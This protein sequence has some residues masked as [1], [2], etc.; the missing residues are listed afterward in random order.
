[1]NTTKR[2][3]VIAKYRKE[4]ANVMRSRYHDVLE[5]DGKIEYKIYIWEDGNIECLE[6]PRG[7]TSRLVPNNGE[8]RKLFYVDTVMVDPSFDPW[9]CTDHSAP[10]DEDER[11]S[12]R[13]EIYDWLEEQYEEGVDIIL[14]SEIIS[15]EMQEDFDAY[16]E[17]S[18][19]A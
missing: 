6:C 8:K 4:L 9:D 12:E 18:N 13:K 3:E 10:E 7:S 14:E 19:N 2:S 17:N 16:V 15:A 5:S 1:M 11:E